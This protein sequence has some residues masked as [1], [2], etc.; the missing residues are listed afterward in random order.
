VNI[1]TI[2]LAA[3]L[4]SL[5]T[6]DPAIPPVFRRELAACPRL[7][8]FHEKT[9]SPREGVVGVHAAM[10]RLPQFAFPSPLSL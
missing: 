1:A 4:R 5:F 10:P 2:T 3:D 9:P 6:L 8:V 7:G